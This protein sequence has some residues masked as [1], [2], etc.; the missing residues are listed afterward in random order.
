MFNRFI[1]KINLILIL[2][3]SGL[4]PLNAAG[5]L[6]IDEFLDIVKETN[7]SIL[8]LQESVEIAEKKY[9]LVKSDYQTKIGL[10]G[11][12]RHRSQ[13]Y[14]YNGGYKLA[15]TYDYSIMLLDKKT[16]SGGEMAI[17]FDGDI[18]N[19]KYPDQA[20]YETARKRLNFKYTQP[21]IRNLLGMSYDRH[22]LLTEKL[23]YEKEEQYLL[24]KI[25][26]ILATAARTYIEYSF[27]VG[28]KQ[29]LNERLTYIDQLIDTLEAQDI[30]E[31]TKKD[32]LKL[33]SKYLKTVQSIRKID[34][35]LI[36]LS[37]KL[38]SMIN[39]KD[40]TFNGLENK[41]LAQY[42]S[43]LTTMKDNYL[44]NS[45]ALE[46]K[47]LDL[48]T[49]K[50]NIKF[51]RNKRLPKL[52]VFGRINY[53][54]DKDEDEDVTVFSD[55]FLFHDPSYVA[56]ANFDWTLFDSTPS[57][58]VDI[59]KL[60]RKQIE[61]EQKRLEQSLEM[62]WYQTVDQLNLAKKASKNL[63]DQVAI[64][65]ELLL[66]EMADLAASYNDDQSDINVAL[67]KRAPFDFYYSSLEPF[68]RT[69]LN[70]E[71]AAID[72]LSNKCDFLVSFYN[73]TYYY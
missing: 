61:L 52:D 73:L 33:E 26:N 71:T 28:K 68:W 39:N 32:I 13:K 53:N 27:Y 10:K 30:K 1:T 41:T 6:F 20:L 24:G 5:G 66:L 64:T 54:R 3:L 55:K 4:Q 42:N 2:M 65:K 19:A 46:L 48:K 38:K 49:K 59:E 22:R 37:Y 21:I 35:E 14:Y 58:K 7:Y 17:T 45:Y 50:L 60:L 56:G 63:S 47:K 9:K 69:L 31:K 72:K 15:N 70:A 18:H 12:A 34:D 43:S 23:K 25:N 8:R 44:D 62:D 67:S 29:V 40:Y 57:L 36:I 11:T 51:Q 16:L